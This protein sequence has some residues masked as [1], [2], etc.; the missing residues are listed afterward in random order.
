MSETASALLGL[1]GIVLVPVVFGLGIHAC[2]EGTQDGPCYGNRTCDPG[3]SCL[4]ITVGYDRCVKPN[5]I[6]IDRKLVNQ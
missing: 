1:F 2:S 3:L 6:K 4:E 5:T